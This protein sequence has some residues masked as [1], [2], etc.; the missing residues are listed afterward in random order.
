M[1]GDQ[2]DRIERAFSLQAAA[3]EDGRL[4]A[5]FTRDVEWIFQTLQLQRDQLLLDVA[6]GT[7]HV[8]RALA[9]QVRVAVAVDTTQAMLDTGK[10]AA[11]FDGLANVVFLRGD[12]AVLPFPDDSFDVWSA[13]SPSITSS[14]RRARWVR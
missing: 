7:G 4:N 13:A 6:A 10:Q 3:F 11:D 1:A 5:P 2:A 8:A 9:P 14:T 12:A